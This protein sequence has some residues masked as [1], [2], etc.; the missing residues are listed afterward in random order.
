MADCDRPGILMRRKIRDILRADKKTSV[1]YERG[2]CGCDI[3]PRR[4]S[5]ISGISM[6]FDAAGGPVRRFF[7]TSNLSVSQEPFRLD[8]RA[9]RLRQIHLCSASCAASP[10]RPPAGC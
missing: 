3:R 8:R 9:K 5:I 7:A 10:S 2:L 1:A 6:V 4:P